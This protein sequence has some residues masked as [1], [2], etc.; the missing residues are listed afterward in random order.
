[1]VWVGVGV[2]VAVCVAVGF[3]LISAQEFPQREQELFEGLVALAGDGDPDLDGLLDEEGGA[4]DQGSAADSIDDALRSGD[5]QGLAL[6]G[7]VFFA[8]GREGLESL[9]FLLA[10]VQQNDGIAV[11][12]GAT[13]GLVRQSAWA[14][15]STIS[16]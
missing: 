16:A 15:R 6:I 4:L 2:A 14:S 8:V 5:R 13:L 7:M 9:F 12:I 3:V 11:P 10:I 1:M